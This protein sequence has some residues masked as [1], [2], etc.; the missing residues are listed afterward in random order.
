MGWFFVCAGL[1]VKHDVTFGVELGHECGVRKDRMYPLRRP[2]IDPKTKHT[3]DRYQRGQSNDVT[4]IKATFPSRPNHT[5]AIDYLLSTARPRGSTLCN[6][7]IYFA[8]SILNVVTCKGTPPFLLTMSVGGT[9]NHTY[10][11]LM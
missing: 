5:S 9:R 3:I 8:K 11:C 1:W 10:S 7:N 6:W 2:A 4:K